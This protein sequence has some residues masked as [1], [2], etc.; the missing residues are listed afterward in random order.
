M[1]LS[2]NYML[3]LLCIALLTQAA[4]ADYATTIVTA[5]SGTADLKWPI[6]SECIINP[7]TGWLDKPN[8]TYIQYPN[9]P[10]NTKGSLVSSNNIASPRGFIDYSD[11]GGCDLHARWF[12]CPLAYNGTIFSYIFFEYKNNSTNTDDYITEAT[13]CDHDG[14]KVDCPSNVAITS[15]QYSKGEGGV[16]IIV[17]PPEKSIEPAMKQITPLNN[18]RVR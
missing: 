5:T 4:Q 13:C 16:E 9:L 17:T 2:I 1:K 18:E 8:G 14:N 11:D 12:I 15:S 6:L 7:S 10:S 3:A